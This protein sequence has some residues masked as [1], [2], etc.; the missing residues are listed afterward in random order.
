MASPP[1]GLFFTNY[2]YNAI[3]IHI[4]TTKEFLLH[5]FYEP[6]H[7]FGPVFSYLY[8]IDLYN[9]YRYFSNIGHKRWNG[10][11]NG[12]IDGTALINIYSSIFALL[13]KKRGNWLTNIDIILISPPSPFLQTISPFWPGFD[14]SIYNWHYVIHSIDTIQI[15]GIKVPIGL[16]YYCYSKT[17]YKYKG[18]KGGV[19]QKRRREV[20]LY[21]Y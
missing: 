18:K 8:I 2:K 19:C 14:L 15:S 1:N 10:C 11:R 13:L 20:W 17:L 9:I 7:P 16:L 21:K 3:I 4:K 5:P 12:E 6:L